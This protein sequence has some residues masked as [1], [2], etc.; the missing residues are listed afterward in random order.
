MP[1]LVTP[2]PPLVKRS[3]GWGVTLPTRVTVLSAMGV[4][5]P[6]D[7][8]VCPGAASGGVD[9]HAAARGLG[10]GQLEQLEA[11]DLVRDAERA[12]ELGEGAGRC[13]GLDHQVVTGVLAVDRIGEGTLAPPVRPTVDRAAGG[14][15]A[16]GDDLDVGL[17]PG[18]LEVAVE[19]DHQFISTH[20]AWK[21]PSGPAAQPGSRGPTREA[22]RM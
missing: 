11:D 22:G 6:C 9:R 20:H 19:D 13:D 17:G 16:V 4:V 7:V 8:R 18:V 5:R 15:D 14:D 1:K 2:R 10:D 12:L 21:P 3:S